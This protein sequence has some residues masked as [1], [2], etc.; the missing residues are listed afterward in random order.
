M[1][2]ISIFIVS[3]LFLTACT[4]VTTQNTAEMSFEIPESYTEV[5]NSGD[6]LVNGASTPISGEKLE[7]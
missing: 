6:I 4:S 7:V 1:N 5:G 2:K 3:F